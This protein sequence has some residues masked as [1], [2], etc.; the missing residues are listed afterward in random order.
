MTDAQQ[1]IC[2]NIHHYILFELTDNLETAAFAW[3]TIPDFG[4][5]LFDLTNR[6]ING[7]TDDLIKTVIRAIERQ[8]TGIEDYYQTLFC[9]SKKTPSRPI[10]SFCGSTPR[11]SCTSTRASQPRGILKFPLLTQPSWPIMDCQQ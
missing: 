8:P 6:A 9:T 5:Y 7:S 4:H 3:T 2:K 11:F 10:L 1:A